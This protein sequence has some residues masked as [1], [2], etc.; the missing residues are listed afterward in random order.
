LILKI[1]KTRF[2]NISLAAVVAVTFS[3]GQID[4]LQP[5]QHPPR[6]W[7]ILKRV[8]NNVF[9]QFVFNN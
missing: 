1:L 5:S 4:K 2:S 8:S 9:I 3:S 7:L 6:E